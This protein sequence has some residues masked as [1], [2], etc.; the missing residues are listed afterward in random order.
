MKFSLPHLWGFL[1][2]SGVI[3]MQH[4]CQYD[5][6]CAGYIPG[7]V[8]AGLICCGPCPS[9]RPCALVLITTSGGVGV[10]PT[11]VCLFRRYCARCLHYRAYTEGIQRHMRRGIV[12]FAKYVAV[13]R[14]HSATRPAA[15]CIG[16]ILGGDWFF[17]CSCMLQVSKVC[18]DG[19]QFE[20]LLSCRR[21]W[22]IFNSAS[23]IL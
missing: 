5:A 1:S 15:T 8:T 9:D 10:S 19:C 18:S 11:T 16:F 7:K 13:W 12:H 22:A 23:S 17:S 20:R 2:V 14:H 21:T 4:S 6:L 3:R